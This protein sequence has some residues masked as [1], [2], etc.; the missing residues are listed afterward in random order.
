[1]ESVGLKVGGGVN[2]QEK[3]EN[4]IQTILE[5]QMMGIINA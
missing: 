2:G 4:R 3:V 1:M 5:P